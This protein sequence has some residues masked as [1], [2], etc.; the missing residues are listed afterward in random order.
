[1]VSIKRVKLRDID[2]SNFYNEFVNLKEPVLITDIFEHFHDLEKWNY[3]Y[4]SEM[5]GKKRINVNVSDNGN[6]TLDPKTGKP[7]FSSTNISIKEYINFAKQ[8][9]IKRKMYAQ[10]ISVL[11]ELPE[12]KE[13]LKIIDYIPDKYLE[14]VNLWFGPGGNTTAL[15]FDGANNFF[16]QLFGEKKIWLYS[17]KYFYSLYPNS[18]T[19]R[20]PHISQ[21]DPGNIDEINYPRA[22]DIEKTEIIISRGNILFLP[23]YWW[24]QVY[25]INSN[26]SVNIWFKPNLMQKLVFAYFHVWLSSLITNL[27]DKLLGIKKLFYK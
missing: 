4:L 19:S 20:A 5:V 16:I 9:N 22:L 7:Y 6:F 11:K 23:A 15:H 18:F 12:L 14:F 25:S 13:D 17:P 24:H 3:D 26:I 10:Q 1:M 27:E 2:V 21:V 8:K